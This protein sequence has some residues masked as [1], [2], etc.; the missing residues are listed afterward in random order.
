M[1][2][3]GNTLN[4]MGE[5]F[6]KALEIA[7]TGDGDRCQKFLTTYVCYIVAENGCSVEE[8]TSIAKSN[9][10]YFAGYYSSDVYETINKAYGAV[11]PIFGQNP[12]D[13]SP[14]DAFR[15]GLG[16]LDSNKFMGSNHII[17]AYTYAKIINREL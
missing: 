11:H 2:F 4:T 1:V 3:E 8:A 17:I 7:K 15:M 16:M 10:G 13:V 6:N 14:E 12:F 9:F 5:I